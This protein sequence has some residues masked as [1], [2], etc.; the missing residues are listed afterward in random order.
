MDGLLLTAYVDNLIIVPYN[1]SVFEKA[2]TL[3]ATIIVNTDETSNN[4]M[5]HVY[6]CVCI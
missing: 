2:A 1:R 5:P 6:K 4:T 3:A